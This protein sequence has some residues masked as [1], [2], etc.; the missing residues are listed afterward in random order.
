MRFQRGLIAEA[1]LHSL[2]LMFNARDGFEREI[3][4]HLACFQ[5]LIN[6]FAE[7]YSE[8]E[9][10]AFVAVGAG[11]WD[12]LYPDARPAEL[13][14]FPHMSKD[15]RKAPHTPYDLFIHIRSDRTDVNHLVGSHV[16]EL[17]GDAVH[18]QEQVKGFRYLD[19]RDL[20][21]FVDG[22]ENPHGAHRRK[23]A[24]V[25]EMQDATFAGGSYVHIQRYRHAMEQWNELPTKVQENI[26]GRTKADNIEYSKEKKMAFSHVKRTGLK[27]E[28]GNSIEILRQ[29]MPY[30]TMKIQGLFFI[31][32]CHSPKPFEIMLRSMIE[33]D[34]RGQHDKLLEYTKAETG[35][36][37]FAPSVDFLRQFL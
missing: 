35:A 17:F 27:D 14:D 10:S 7:D 30:G 18:L 25:D 11:Y 2:Y 5:A 37:F 29:S 28:N 3:R 22:T 24:L 1:N 20:T 31:S 36:A 12:Q 6:Q 4:Q 26:I 9:L 15:N 32:V 13:C 16:V 8:A 23:V 21:G 33:G 34:E 19:G